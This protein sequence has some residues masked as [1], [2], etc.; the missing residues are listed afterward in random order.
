MFVVYIQ[1]VQCGSISAECKT[2]WLMMKHK[3]DST[4]PQVWFAV[5]G[6]DVVDW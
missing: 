2:V 4:M 5:I 1:C 3:N 6:C